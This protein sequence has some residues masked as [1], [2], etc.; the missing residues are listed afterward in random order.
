LMFVP[1]QNPTFYRVR[2][3]LVVSPNHQFNLNSQDSLKCDE[4]AGVRFNCLT[5]E[6]ETLIMAAAKECFHKLEKSLCFQVA[7]FFDGAEVR[8]KDSLHTMLFKMVKKYGHVGAETQELVTIMNKRRLKDL[9][10]QDASDLFEIDGG[11]E[12]LS[13]SDKKTLKS[14]KKEIEA[15]LQAR[16]TYDKEFRSLQKAVR[17]KR[18]EL[19]AKQL[20][21]AKAKAGGK[22][23]G[24][25]GAAGK[26]ARAAVVLH[27][28][29]PDL[30]ITQPMMKELLPPDLPAR[31]WG[32]YQTER[33]R[34]VYDENPSMQR[35]WCLGGARIAG[36]VADVVQVNHGIRG[37]L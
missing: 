9:G 4:K 22:G 31:V 35:R 12:V 25:G 14:E 33:W 27:L 23:P 8:R 32:D 37:I 16:Q 24:K 19:V 15:A 2:R 1:V 6:P 5:K 21:D 28:P 29:P 10:A 13:S 18:K 17:E 36:A 30:E 11:V 20:A 3:V 34:A 7:Q 26:G